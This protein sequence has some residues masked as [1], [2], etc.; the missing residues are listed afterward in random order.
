MTHNPKGRLNKNTSKVTEKVEYKGDY[1]IIGTVRTSTPILGYVVLELKTLQMRLFTVVQTHELMKRFKFEN[2]VIDEVG[3]IYN[4]ECSME[5][6]PVFTPSR[7]IQRN[8]NLIILGRI[9]DKDAELLGFRVL[10]AFSSNT[11]KVVDMSEKK[12]IDFIA[13]S[14]LSV[15]NAKLMQKKDT[16]YIS[17]IKGNFKLIKQVVAES[18][19]LEAVN[20]KLTKSV[21]SP[22]SLRKK[23][24]EIFL[25]K[26]QVLFVKELLTYGYIKLLNSS[27]RKKMAK[28]VFKE[29]IAV[30]YPELKKYASER[31]EHI[32]TVALLLGLVKEPF[33]YKG[34]SVSIPK[35]TSDKTLRSIKSFGITHNSLTKQLVPISE[36]LLNFVKEN[37][38]Q[39]DVYKYLVTR[40]TAFHNSKDNIK[41][42]KSSV[43]LGIKHV[44]IANLVDNLSVKAPNRGSRS[45]TPGYNTLS[46]R[47]DDL[48]GLAHMGYTIDDNIVGQQFESIVYGKIELRNALQGVECSD[49]DKEFIIENIK[50]YGDLEI[51]RKLSALH[52]QPPSEELHVVCNSLIFILA[53]HNPTI[54][55]FATRYYSDLVF[56]ID[57]VAKE[58]FF[59]TYED[60]LY[61]ESGLRFCKGVKLRR[62]QSWN[63]LDIVPRATRSALNLHIVSNFSIPLFLRT[64]KIKG[65]VLRYSTS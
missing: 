18:T 30:E 37:D 2:A 47:F 35:S 10:D 39:G 29:Y 60:R 27:N 58:N 57:T 38:T 25:T 14:G 16:T 54:A 15:A 65:N 26:S 28:V 63:G 21:P 12:L 3:E 62:G 23:N 45:E 7:R 20:S 50:A 46:I 9:V 41:G 34:R 56:D 33:V 13:S 52:K 8:A 5:R 6:L 24:H 22:D 42:K 40:N 4:T 43:Q 11:A 32:L 59:L 61:Y 19:N 1:R 48:E 44:Q 31:P 55:H 53:M 64:P 51:L 49:A 36:D 17:A